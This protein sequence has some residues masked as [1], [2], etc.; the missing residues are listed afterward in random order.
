MIVFVPRVDLMSKPL[1]P[2]RE[3]SLTGGRVTSY[4]DL[5]RESPS[6]VR[7]SIHV[8]LD[9]FCTKQLAKLFERVDSWDWTLQQMI[10]F[11][12]TCC[13]LVWPVIQRTPLPY[14]VVSCHPLAATVDMWA[15]HTARSPRSE[16]GHGTGK[17][18]VETNL[19]W[20]HRYL[21]MTICKLYVT[22][23]RFCQ[24]PYRSLAIQHQAVLECDF[25]FVFYAASKSENHLINFTLGS[26]DL[27]Q[28]L[29]DSMVAEVRTTSK[30]S[31]RS[32]F[33]VM[34]FWRGKMLPPTSW[35]CD[36]FWK[37]DLEV[38]R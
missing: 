24:I 8:T 1:C 6:Y 20:P 7:K 18:L 21:E 19:T 29:L 16:G 35:S 14:E 28:Q 15:Q 22:S 3:V 23:V 37:G 9:H 12:A 36:S 30:T 27:R 26:I 33:E 10:I 4:G 34:I 13:S 38:Q 25:D 2:P 11:L 17:N 32:C 5:T 31:S